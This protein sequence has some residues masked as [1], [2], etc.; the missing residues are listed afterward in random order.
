MQEWRTNLHTGSQGYTGGLVDAIVNTLFP[1]PL[2]P[3]RQPQARQLP[4][5][6][7]SSSV[8]DAVAA[9]ASSS[10]PRSLHSSRSAFHHRRQRSFD[11]APGLQPT[12]LSA[13]FQDAGL[14]SAYT[15]LH[16]GP[17]GRSTALSTSSAST[18]GSDTRSTG[19]SQKYS[20][21]QALSGQRSMPA[22]Q[23]VAFAVREIA[24]LVGAQQQAV[25]Q[26][27][28]LKA[29]V[30]E[31]VHTCRTALDLEAKVKQLQVQTQQV[32]IC[33]Y[34]HSTGACV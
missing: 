26:S 10:T 24:E 17:H 30:A 13:R 29:R 34:K 4:R 2:P 22:M 18:A 19:I 27:V 3:A 6:T 8:R 25:A 32:S 33:S 9:G 20:S 15:E 14:T 11:S 12:T 1:F 31:A 5:N 7:S 23:Y 21:S 16:L 28:N